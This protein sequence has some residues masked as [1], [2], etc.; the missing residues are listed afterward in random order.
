MANAEYQAWWRREIQLSSDLSRFI[1]WIQG[2]T[3]GVIFSSGGARIGAQLGM[4]QALCEYDK[5]PID[6]VV[7]TEAGFLLAACYAIYQDYSHVQNIIE[8][9][10]HDFDKDIA[11]LHW[12]ELTF[13]FV[14]LGRTGKRLLMY[15]Y[16]LFGS[17][18]LEDTWIPICCVTTN[19]T[20]QDVRVDRSGPMWAFLRAS[21]SNVNRSPPISDP[22][23]HDYIIDG[24]HANSLPRM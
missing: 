20:T 3:Y 24:S 1:R 7:G 23:D 13:P 8:K 11:K 10:F 15:L 5:I 2:K 17:V 19:L 16:Q 21:L 6:M 4:L 22:N 14:N 12:D 18:Q 9:I